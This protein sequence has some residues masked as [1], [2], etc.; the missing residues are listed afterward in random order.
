MRVMV[1]AGGTTEKI[2]SVRSIANISTGRLGSLIAD[3]FAM[4]PEVDEVLYVCSKTA[5]LPQGD[6]INV[7]Y[8]DNVAS[9]E[10]EIRTILNATPVDIIVHSMAVSDY[11]V[12]AVTSASILADSMLA[13]GDRLEH[14][15]Q[16]QVETAVASLIKNACSVIGGNGKISSDIDHMLLLM[17]RTPKIIALF[18]TLAPKAVLVGFKLLDGVPHD[19]L[20]DT[21]FRLLETNRCS[22]VLAN[23]LS[24][25]SEQG[26]IGYLVDRYKHYE[27]FDTKGAIAQGIVSAV[28]KQRRGQA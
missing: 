11:R 13:Q 2:D 7:R 18:Q 25:I 4:L 3:A 17:E 6:Q 19:M 27:R 5:A 20:I 28:M 21:A 9:L 16:E 8:I 23:D 14:I 26:H 1:T 15:P 24:G 22:F 12:A 10:N